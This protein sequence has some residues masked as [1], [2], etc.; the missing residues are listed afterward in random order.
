MQNVTKDLL[1]EYKLR[2]QVPYVRWKRDLIFTWPVV[3]RGSNYVDVFITLGPE[4]LNQYLF[5]CHGDT[6]GSH[7]KRRLGG[8]PVFASLMCRSKALG[9]VA[10]SHKP[11][12]LRRVGALSAS[13]KLEPPRLRGS[14]SG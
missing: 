1:V 4:E 3:V 13:F 8:L 14:E 9:E 7:C 5:Q 12:V 6:S 10:V 11:R 2:S